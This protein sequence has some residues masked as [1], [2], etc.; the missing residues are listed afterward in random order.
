MRIG[1]HAACYYATVFS[2]TKSRRF[3]TKLDENTRLSECFYPIV[4]AANPAVKKIEELIKTHGSFE[5]LPDS[6]EIE[7][8][9]QFSVVVKTKR[10]KTFKDIPDTGIEMTPQVQGL[11]L[12]LSK[13]LSSQEEKLLKESFPET[14]FKKVLVL[15]DGRTPS[16][17][18]SCYARMALGAALIPAGLLLGIIVA[19]RG[20]RKE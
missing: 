10:F 5:K 17:L 14:D 18:T 9:K 6:V 16:S 4:S 8:P 19:L 1:P 2:Y 11:I 12:N 3:R 7:P 20:R 15:E 13:P